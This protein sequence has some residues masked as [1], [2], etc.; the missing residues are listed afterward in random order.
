MQQLQNAV[1]FTLTADRHTAIE[2]NPC[3]ID[4]QSSY[5]LNAVVP[6]GVSC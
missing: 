1:L 2:A 5:L 6:A 4:K 3:V